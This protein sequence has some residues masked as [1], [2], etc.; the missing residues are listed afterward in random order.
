MV[1]LMDADLHQLI[2]Q[3]D[4]VLTEPHIKCLMKQLLEALKAMHSLGVYHRDIKPG[5]ILVNQDCQLRITDF[6]FARHLSAGNEEQEAPL[7]EYVVTRW[8]R[9]PELL[10]APSTAY[11]EAVDMWSAGCIL[12]EMIGRKPLFPGSGYI[13]QVQQIF[14]LL[15][16]KDIKDLGFPVSP[17]NAAFLNSKCRYPRKPLSRLFPTYSKHSLSVLDSLLSVCPA[18]RPSAVDALSHPFFADAETLFDYSQVN[19]PRPSPDFFDFESKGF[20][21]SKLAGMIRTDVAK[22][23]Y[24]N[25]LPR[26]HQQ[27]F[28]RFDSDPYANSLHTGRTSVESLEALNEGFG[29]DTN[30]GH[31][32]EGE[33]EAETDGDFGLTILPD[34]SLHKQDRQTSFG[35][36]SSHKGD[37]LKGGEGRGSKTF[38]SNNPFSRKN[39]TVKRRD[40]LRTFPTASAVAATASSS[41]AGAGGAGDQTSTAQSDSEVERNPSIQRHESNICNANNKSGKVSMIKSNSDLPLPTD[42]SWATTNVEASESTKTFMGQTGGPLPRLSQKGDGFQGSHPSH[43]CGFG[44]SSSGCSGQESNSFPP[45]AAGA[46][47]SA[48][49]LSVLPQL[50]A[51]LMDSKYSSKL[52]EGQ[53]VHGSFFCSSEFALDP[54]SRKVESSRGKRH[55]I[56][57]S[58]NRNRPQ[59]GLF[60]NGRNGIN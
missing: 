48:D 36:G 33:A 6:G 44:G 25:D 42:S 47:T 15:G 3:S 23:R 32:T 18:T 22:F 52:L 10:L 51:I 8:Y 17:S 60:S 49:S 30:T 5:N 59:S 27:S 29:V 56:R 1:E 20:D 40:R 46:M 21:K 2:N 43:G 45:I 11:S 50:P 9:A 12:G 16:L 39:S 35:A 19:L 53:W 38:D 37:S 4:Q 34:G 57:A 26:L 28:C 24:E 31:A 41:D 58:N 14:S 54:P 7:T 55:S 13:D